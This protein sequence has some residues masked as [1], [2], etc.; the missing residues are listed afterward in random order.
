ME[1]GRLGEYLLR[2]MAPLICWDTI[3]LHLPNRVLI[4]VGMSQV[5]PVACSFVDNHYMHDAGCLE[6]MKG[7]YLSGMIVQTAFVKLLKQIYPLCTMTIVLTRQ[8][9]GNPRFH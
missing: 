4:R 5:T 8:I 2:A 6:N 3:E 1:Y 9:I 7:T